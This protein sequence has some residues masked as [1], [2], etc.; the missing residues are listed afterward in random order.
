M[1]LGLM[2]EIRLTR[3][4]VVKF[5]QYCFCTVYGCSK[6]KMQG[7]I[8][9]SRDAMLVR[10]LLWPCVRLSVRLSVCHKSEFY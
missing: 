7:A 10:Y 2:A 9:L 4:L 5:W 6:Q 1:V 3:T 8:F